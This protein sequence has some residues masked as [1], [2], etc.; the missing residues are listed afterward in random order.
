MKLQKLAVYISEISDDPSE[1]CKK[2]RDQGL[3]ALCLRRVW[4]N[5]IC[6][7]TDDALGILK[8]MLVD[9]KVALI[10]TDV[11][12]VEPAL[13]DQQIEKLERAIHICKYFQ[14]QHVALHV[15]KIVCSTNKLPIIPNNP[16]PNNGAT[17]LDPEIHLSWSGGDPDSDDI[18]TY[19]IYFGKTIPPPK[20]INNQATNT[21]IPESLDY[22]TVYYWRVVTH[23]NYGATTTGPI[24]QFTTKITNDQDNISNKI[25]LNIRYPNERLL[26]RSIIFNGGN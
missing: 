2:L 20:I 25:T 7:L 24:W 11:G 5:N 23:D 26:S 6:N 17:E 3:S 19:D 15:G 22:N 12:N 16:I 4:Q 8:P 10:Y 1:A 13:L 18:V 14:C 21:Y 9:L